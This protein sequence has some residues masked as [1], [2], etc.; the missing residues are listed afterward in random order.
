MGCAHGVMT[1]NKTSK[2]YRLEDFQKGMQIRSKVR[3]CLMHC[4]GMV[5]GRPIFTIWSKHKQRWNYYIYP[6][7]YFF[8]KDLETG[9]T[10]EGWDKE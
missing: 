10:V 2:V 8:P 7:V 4:R 3:N 1:V 5:D 9:I 6:D